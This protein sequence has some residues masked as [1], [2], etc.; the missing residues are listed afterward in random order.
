[1]VNARIPIKTAFGK[2]LAVKDLVLAFEVHQPFRIRRDFFWGRR[3]FR[4]L[5]TEGLFEYY[6]DDDANR[7]VFRRVAEKAYL[8]TNRII[9]RAIEEG[10][11]ENSPVNVAFS[12]SGVF[13]EQCERYGKDV[14]ESFERLATTGHVEFICQTYY[15][16]L[17]GFHSSKD[18]FIQQV[19]MHRD[20]VRENF[21]STP[22]LFENTEFLYNNTI[23]REIEAL[24]F[25]GIFTEGARRILGDRSPNRVYRARGCERLKVLLRNYTLTDDVAFRFSSRWWVEWPLTA[26]K[27][28]RWLNATP[29][30]CIIIFPDYETFGEHQWPETGIHEFL[31]H[32]FKEVRRYPDLTMTLPSAILARREPVDAIDVPEFETISWA[33]IERGTS[34][35]LGNAMQWAYF[36]TLRDQEGLVSEAK[37]S[38]VRTTWRRFQTSDHLYYMFTAG[39]A[40][41][42]VHSY[43]NPF[44]TPMDA[45][46][47]CFSAL[48]DFDVRLREQTIAANEP[49]NFHTKAGDE[50]Y[51][52]ISVRSLKG[53]KKALEKVS[54]RS[55][56]FHNRR[57]DIGHWFRLSLKMNE[58]ADE[59]EKLKNL[60]GNELRETLLA[61]VER[62]LQLRSLKTRAGTE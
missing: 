43:F 36:T 38:E 8:P 33:D 31:V 35:W 1:M 13:L 5:G 32:L 23:A 9:L 51:T 30:D 10:E 7:K 24:G 39:G 45:F 50:G 55:L 25:D 26:D 2:E 44:G 22:K 27:Y 59:V 58:L 47:T 3:N 19:N 16:S 37:S 17:A 41:G 57:G 42:E 21:D 46:V 60:R 15:H 62:H 48:L 49:F 4:R 53:F 40:P 20:A 6:F 12:I 29:G 11:R 34:S 54:L 61:L 28:A 18:E 52:G 56:E 14:L